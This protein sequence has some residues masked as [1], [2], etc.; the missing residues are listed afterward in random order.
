M[1]TDGAGGHEGRPQGTARAD[2]HNSAR[3]GGTQYITGGG[4]VRHVNVY[5]GPSGPAEPAS[6]GAAPTAAA[7]SGDGGRRLAARLR[8]PLTAGIA[9]LAAG[10]LA[11]YFHDAPRTSEAADRRDAHPGAAASSTPSAS[12]SA[13]ATTSASTSASA[14]ASTGLPA[15]ARPPQTAP[16]PPSGDTA[17]DAPGARGA[18]PEPSAS[19]T[20]R[21]TFSRSWPEDDRYCSKWRATAEPDVLMRSCTFPDGSTGRASFGTQVTNHGSQPVEL[22]VQV[23]YAQSGKSL[24]CSDSTRPWTVTLAPGGTWR[25][26]LISCTKSSLHGTAVQAEGWAASSE[27]SAPDRVQGDP[28]QSVTLH[29]NERGEHT[30]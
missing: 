27:Y 13:S 12:A 17:D 24:G 28:V 10:A 3:A 2:Q 6:G 19:K 15:D 23:G 14:S 9:L 4:D 25:S 16:P 20:V 1:A 5:L 21:T 8:T 30:P 26:G 11:L 18:D 7:V 29:Y 22:S